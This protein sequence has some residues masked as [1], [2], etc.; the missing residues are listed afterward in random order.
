MLT[1]K[2]GT[3][4]KHQHKANH[5]QFSTHVDESYSA[6]T[7]LLDRRHSGHSGRGTINP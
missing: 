5:A 6:V 4:K 2:Q 3:R 7:V 1:S